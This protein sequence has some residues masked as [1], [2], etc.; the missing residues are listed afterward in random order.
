MKYFLDTEFIEGFQK[1]LFGKKRHHIDLISIGMVCEDGRCYSAL[2]NEYS[3]NDAD[4]WVKDNVILPLY[5]EIKDVDKSIKINNFNKLLGSSNKTIALDII[6]FIF[7]GM[8]KKDNVVEFYGYYSDYDWVVFCSIFGKMINLPEKF[9]KYCRDLKQ[10]LDEKARRIMLPI[11]LKNKIEKI[12]SYPNYPKQSNEHNALADAQW[13][14]D[15]Y[16][17]L[18]ELN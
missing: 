16:N 14:F 3:Y 1:P 17:F 5:N 10:T 15:L 18:K 7:D 2:S 4:D 13:N 11:S 12:K 8:S 6:K 9:P